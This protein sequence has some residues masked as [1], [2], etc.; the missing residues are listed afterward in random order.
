MHDDLD[1]G[2]REGSIAAIDAPYFA[3]GTRICTVRRADDLP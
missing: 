3:T 2:T 1:I